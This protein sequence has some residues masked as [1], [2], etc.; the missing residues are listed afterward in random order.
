MV[1]T[2]LKQMEPL[3]KLRRG[4]GAV[5]RNKEGELMGDNV[6]SLTC[7]ISPLGTE[8]LARIKGWHP[9]CLRYKD[10]SGYGGSGRIAWKWQ[11]LSTLTNLVGQ[12]KERLYR[13]SR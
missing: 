1:G 4:I 9:I 6:V 10:Y 2:N 11:G 7:N 13:K 5:V 12:R 8:L 3:M